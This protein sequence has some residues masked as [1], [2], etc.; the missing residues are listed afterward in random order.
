MES[1]PIRRAAPHLHSSVSVGASAAMCLLLALGGCGGGSGGSS[2]SGDAAP[3]VSVAT[4]A[5][6]DSVSSTN[7]EVGK[8]FTIAG[9]NL[10]RVTSFSVNGVGLRIVAVSANSA[11]LAMPTA[12]TS[13]ALSLVINGGNIL[14]GYSLTA[15][16]TMIVEGFAP[17]AAVAGTTVMVTGAGL[18]TVFQVRFANGSTAPVIQ[19]HGDLDLSF[20][21]PEGAG[22]GT[23]SLVSPYGEAKAV[24]FTVFPTVGVSSI[25]SSSES[26]LRVTVSGSNLN[27]VTTAKVGA[28][29]ATI[30]Q[31]SATQ[32]ILT[33]PLGT[34]G[35]VML[36]SPAGDVNAGAVSSQKYMIGTVDVAQVFSRNIA[37][38]SLKLTPGRPMLVRA[39]VLGLI[40]NLDSPTVKLTGTTAEGA[41]LGPL[42]MAGPAKLPT[43]R[44]EYDLA[45]TFSVVVPDT[46]ASSGLKLAVSATN[47]DNS[48]VSGLTHTPAIGTNT[49]V[50][51]Y[52]V[53]ISYNGV[54]GKLPVNLQ[55]VKDA[56][57]RT[58]PY[59][60]ADITVSVRSMLVVNGSGTTT[61][62]AWWENALPQLETARSTEH[63]TAFY[64]G[65]VHKDSKPGITGLAY[66]NN[67][68]TGAGYPSAIGI[69]AD[70]SPGNAIDPFGNLWPD[71]LG[72]M[73]HEVG[74]NHSLNHVGGCNNPDAVDPAYP[75]NDGVLGPMPVYNSLYTGVVPGALKRAVYGTLNTPMKD[76]MTYCSDGAWLSDF[77]YAAAQTFAQARS[78]TSATYLVPQMRTV[79]SGTNDYLTV[80]GSISDGAVRLNPADASS[81][82]RYPAAVGSSHDYT[83][84]VRTTAGKTFDYAFDAME[85]GDGGAGLRHFNVSLP[86]P[87]EIS[88]I[89]VFYKSTQLAQPAAR[90]T[91]PSGIPA[92]ASQL[93]D[94]K[95]NLTWNPDVEP[96]ATVTYVGADGSRLLLAKNLRGG[97]AGID[98]Q[99][100]PAGGSFEV[101]L[102]TNLKARLVKIAR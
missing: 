54:T 24:S 28:V 20:V 11:T 50:H 91:A 82:R 19:P 81:Q 56:F 53:P 84:R 94:G 17:S 87:G 18:G 22:S 46:W 51:L 101:S 77:S 73:L 36:T 41:V 27:A 37:N 10:D 79:D 60:A 14:T 29:T 4:T 5:V 3:A 33:A 48:V 39:S 65:F 57:S 15:Y 2:S 34:S 96:A 38:T 99:G 88:G 72:T 76:V 70:N 44:D 89:D 67:R 97:S 55:S 75:Y 8:T 12:P 9:S 78:A 66:V 100:L 32:L 63:P 71:W 23:V 64:Y 13:G 98:I 68:N 40:A 95:L 35:N 59:G 102:S 58:Y 26:V 6:V 90:N 16:A 61:D 92:F 31:A 62:S 30:I 93:S 69:E 52:L 43:S 47:A 83:L 7:V 1:L 25:S 86:N 42:V 45:N 21:V 74:H 49:K 85:V 80:S